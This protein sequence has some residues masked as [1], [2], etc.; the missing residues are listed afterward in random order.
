[1]KL[2]WLLVVLLA[3]FVASG[4]DDNG[5]AT[6]PTEIAVPTATPAPAV[7]FEVAG[8]SAP[9]TLGPGTFSSFATYVLDT[10]TRKLHTVEVTE[11]ERNSAEQP[12]VFD[13]WTGD[14]KLRFSG[15]AGSWEVALDGAVTDAA[16]RPTS[17]PAA[18]PP[19]ASA[20]DAWR[21]R[22]EGDGLVVTNRQVSVVYRL[23]AWAPALQWAPNG[24]LAAFSTDACHG[25]ELHVLDPD[26]GTLTKL[27]HAGQW[28]LDWNW[29][30][31]GT[32]I[33]GNAIFEQPGLRLF[34]VNA[35]SSEVL[36]P[37]TEG[38]E[39]V[40]LRWTADGRFL[41]FRWRGGR[42]FGC[43]EGGTEIPYIAPRLERICDGGLC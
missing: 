41:A 29:H 20:D 26:A 1:M 2:S 9:D 38:G 5:R 43:G 32:R 21:T 30:P 18:D 34:D 14:G 22:R 11:I 25:G 4:C 3:A 15:S 42:D 17:S 16:V 10:E 6:P 28:V 7:R 13:G 39:L 12:V 31:D 35:R 36:V 27:T 24:H 23:V 8:P 40:P 19:N 33:A 37:L